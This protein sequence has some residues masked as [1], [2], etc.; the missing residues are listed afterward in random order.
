MEKKN[1]DWVS[2]ASGRSYAGG[3]ASG[4]N[5]EKGHGRE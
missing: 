3:A 4:G 5:T 2:V 1:N